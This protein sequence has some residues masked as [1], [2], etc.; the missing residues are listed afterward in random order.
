[1]QPVEMKS[2]HLSAR[3]MMYTICWQITPNQIPGGRRLTHSN[4]LRFPSL[5]DNVSHI[6]TTAAQALQ[7]QIKGGKSSL[8]TNG[9]HP[10]RATSN[11]P[12]L[13]RSS[14]MCG[15]GSLWG[16]WSVA[17]VEARGE[18]RSLDA[19]DVSPNAA[20]KS[21][22]SLPDS[23]TSAYS[24]GALM[25]PHLIQIEQK[26]STEVLLMNQEPARGMLITGGLGGLGLLIASWFALQTEQ[27]SSIE[28][29]FA[30][31]RPSVLL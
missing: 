16:L 13:D 2:A 18:Q 14:F 27:I 1:M 7:L 19:F 8:Q 3:N 5:V 15:L 26:I 4:Y 23:S 17:A 12:C 6:T 31:S 25:S 29:S 20:S 22:V 10:M 28:S 11:M 30:Y 9:I 24:S 21:Q